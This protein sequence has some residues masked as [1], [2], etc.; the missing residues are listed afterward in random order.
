MDLRPALQA[1]PG[2]VDRLWVAYSAG[3]DSVALLHLLQPFREHYELGLWHVHHGL[4]PNADAMAEQARI[5]ARRYGI[6]CRI[7]RLRLDP[8]Q[9]NLEATAREARY[10]LFADGLDARS[11][12]LTAHH[13]DDQAET[14]LL[15]LMRG[16]GPAGLAGIARLRPLGRGWLLRPLLDMTRRDIHNCVREAG[17]DWV[18]DPSNVELH[19]DRNFLRHRV[20]PLLSERWPAA[21]SSLK[22]AADWQSE[23]AGL[24]TQLARMDA[25]H[26]L[27]DRPFAEQL[28]VDLDSLQKLNAARQK[29][30]LRH[31]LLQAGHAIDRRRLEQLVEQS[32]AREDAQ[33]EVRLATAVLRRYRGAWYLCALHEEAPD[34]DVVCRDTLP[35]AVQK[36]NRH[37]LK[38][39]F[40]QAGVPPWRRGRIP[41]RMEG[42]RVV[43]LERSYSSG[44]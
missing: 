20:L 40:Q 6:E 29:N 9:P 15:A 26:C 22:Q 32:G 44:R 7:D 10:R 36:R 19:A 39:L 25:R 13:R 1:L 41:L 8:D 14:L 17:L 27:I 4:Q 2:E 33:P 38:R 28:C 5:A 11:A 23:T 37:R 16:A 43:G 31:W 21:A 3:I 30:L 12:L 18:E 34:R 42:D 24:L 35:L